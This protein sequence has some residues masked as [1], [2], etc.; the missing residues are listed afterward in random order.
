MARRWRKLF[1]IV[2]PIRGPKIAGTATHPFIEPVA[3]S[4][5]GKEL[6]VKLTRQSSVAAKALSARAAASGTLR[7]A[8]P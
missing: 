6:D 8:L 4:V 5:S 7:P 3:G 2:R 1:E